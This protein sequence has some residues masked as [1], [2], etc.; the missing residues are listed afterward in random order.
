MSVGEPEKE[1]RK[2]K[3]FKC[4]NLTAWDI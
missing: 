2:K 3:G 1:K 4:T